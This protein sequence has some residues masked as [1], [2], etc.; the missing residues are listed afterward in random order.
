MKSACVL[1]MSFVALTVSLRAQT[2]PVLDKIVAVVGNEIILKSELD[3]QLQ[4]TAHQNN[5]DPND[6]QL[7]NRVLEALVDD[8]LILAQAILDS[9]TVTDDEVDRQLDNRI[10]NL[11]KQLGSEQ[12]VEE[13]YGMSINKIRTE[14]RDDMRKQL[15]VEKLKQQKFGDMKVSAADVRNFYDTYKD[16]LPQVPEQFTLSHI[17][18][19]PKPSSKARDE[20]YLLAKQILDSVR[21]GADFAAFAKKYSQDPGSASA[22]GDLGGQSAANSSPVRAYRFQS[23]TE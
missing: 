4:L 21:G 13:L 17:F 10:Q 11:V 5:L 9:V 1:L 14:F 20:A 6:S 7:R 23:E 22:G 15:I 3:Y 19:I 2:K 16:S 12:K 8:K 18:M